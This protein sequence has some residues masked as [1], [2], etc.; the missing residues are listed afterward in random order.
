[1]LVSMN[2]AEAIDGLRH[3]QLKAERGGQRHMPPAI[4]AARDAGMKEEQIAE[5]LDMSPVQVAAIAP[6][7]P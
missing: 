1:M 7:E 6:I 4:Q 5:E 2:E 3:A